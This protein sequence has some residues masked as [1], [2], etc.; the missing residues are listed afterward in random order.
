MAFCMISQVQ[1]AIENFGRISLNIS[2]KKALQR[3]ATAR[4]R[5]VYSIMSADVQSST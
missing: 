5:G 3:K 2:T 4:Q 1:K